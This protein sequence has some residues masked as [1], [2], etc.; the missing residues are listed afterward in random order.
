[1]VTNPPYLTFDVPEVKGQ[2]AGRGVRLRRAQLRNFDV[3]Q[4][5]GRLRRV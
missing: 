2:I 3:K 5:I 1:M 4:K